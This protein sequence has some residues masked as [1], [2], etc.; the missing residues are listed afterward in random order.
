M[1]IFNDLN[2]KTSLVYPVV[3]FLISDVTSV[4]FSLNR[5]V[6]LLISH[7]HAHSPVSLIY[8]ARLHTFIIPQSDVVIFLNDAAPILF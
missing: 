6:F 7:M 1:R 8:S 3:E 4:C 2:L 5:F